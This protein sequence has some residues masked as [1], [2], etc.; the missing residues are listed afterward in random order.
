MLTHSSKPVIQI[1]KEKYHY[2]TAPVLSRNKTKLGVW[3]S[4]QA[5]EL[6]IFRVV[7]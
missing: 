5:P 6:H 1:R 2:I 7:K 4:S 3:D